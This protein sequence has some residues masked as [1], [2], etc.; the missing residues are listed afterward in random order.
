MQK[1]YDYYCKYNKKDVSFP[2]LITGKCEGC[3]EPLCPACGY[4]LDGAKYCNEC[5]EKE[6]AHQ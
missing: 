6:K 4:V 3:D 5:Y 2:A 1:H